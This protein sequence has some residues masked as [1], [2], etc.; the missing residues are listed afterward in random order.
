MDAVEAT[1]TNLRRDLPWDAD[2]Q[3]LLDEIV[4]SHPV[5]TRISAAKTL[6]DAAEKRAL[7]A[8]GARVDRATVARLAPGA[9]QVSARERPS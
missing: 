5:L 8:G 3:T 6:R 4:A 1:P 7:D 9:S 2:A